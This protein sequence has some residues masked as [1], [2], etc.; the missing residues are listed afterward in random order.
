MKINVLKRLKLGLALWGAFGVLLAIS[1]TQSAVSVN[2]ISA[3]QSAGNNANEGITQLSG[4]L[5]KVETSANQTA[6]EVTEIANRVKLDLAES[7]K[8][9]AMDMQVLQRNVE[10]TV[11]ATSNIVDQLESLLDESD[12]DDDTAGVIEDLLFEAEDS[13]DAIRKEALP[14]VRTG[15]E[16]LEKTAETSDKTSVEISQ[17]TATMDSFA[18]TSQES[19]SQAQEVNGLIAES[20]QLSSDTKWLIIVAAAVG[21]VVG[22]AVPLILVPLTN[23]E[24][25]RAVETLKGVAAGDLSQ[26]LESQAFEE[27]SRVADSLNKALASMDQAVRTIRCGASDLS[28]S[29]DNLNGTANSLAAGAEQTTQLSLQV[30]AAAEEMSC[31]LTEVSAAVEQ[32][33]S[34]NSSI[35]EATDCMLEELDTVSDRVSSAVSVADEASTLVEVGSDKI[36]RLGAAATEISEVSQTIQDIADMTNLLALNATIEAARAGEAGKGFAVVASEVKD[37]ANQTSEATVHIREQIDGIQSASTDAISAVQQIDDVIK[38][39]RD[40]STHIST[41]V[42]EQ[43]ANTRCIADQITQD[44][45]A[46]NLVASNISQTAMASSEIAKSISEVDKAARSTAESANDTRSSGIELTKLSEQLSDSLEVFN[47]H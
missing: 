22:F 45:N 46:A 14:M 47:V 33:S 1:A 43:K 16:R 8:Q 38:K 28:D 12:L 40:E 6:V 30:S 2:I 7:M 10:K 24:V 19:S 32:V 34:N 26:R 29:S 39:V 23:K 13:A 20:T 37:L 27:F 44:A 5:Q 41:S 36:R 17:L 3:I 25:S 31:S 21:M 9:G 35:S 4:N 15:V 11:A 42:T 18:K